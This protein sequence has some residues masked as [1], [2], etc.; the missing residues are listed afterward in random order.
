VRPSYF[1]MVAAGEM[2]DFA[3]GVSTSYSMVMASGGDDD[4]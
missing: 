4:N 3:T 2:G 1:D